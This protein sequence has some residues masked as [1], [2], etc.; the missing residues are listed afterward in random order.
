MPSRR[1]SK[2]RRPR[3]ATPGNKP[4]R[5]AVRRAFTHDRQIFPPTAVG[6][7]DS[8]LP[9]M[10]HCHGAESP[11][12]NCHFRRQPPPGLDVSRL[13]NLAGLVAHGSDT[14]VRD[15]ID[16]TDRNRA[17][18]IGKPSAYA[19]SSFRPVTDAPHHAHHSA[20]ETYRNDPD[21]LSLAIA[22]RRKWQRAGAGFS[23]C[24]GP[25]KGTRSWGGRRKR[26]RRAL[27]SA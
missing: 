9:A 5:P 21:R 22:R 10:D 17:K 27:M 26:Q 19:A 6:A 1:P 2:S 15:R 8:V 3:Q 7:G 20:K 11:P 14:D 4:A 16:T 18:D 13:G 12:Y 23:R 24:G 25:V